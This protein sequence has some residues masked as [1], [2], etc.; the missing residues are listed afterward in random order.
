MFENHVGI[1][2]TS[3]KIQLVEI[4]FDSGRFYLNNIDEEYFSEFIDFSDKETKLLSIIQSSFDD[5]LLRRRL[6]SNFVSFSVPH[7]QF[8]FAQ[9]PYDKTLVVNDLIEHFKWELSLMYPGERPEELALQHIEV[10]KNK[11]SLYDAVI[12]IALKKRIIKLLNQ[13]CLSNKLKLKYIDNVHL[14]AGVSSQLSEKICETSLT[15]SAFISENYLSIEFTLGSD[16]IRFKVY[17]LNHAGEIIPILKDELRDKID[18]N[19]NP[20]MISRA[21]VL[22]DNVTE[23]FIEQA[24]NQLNIQFKKINPFEKIA[25]NEEIAD[26]NFLLNKTFSFSSAAGIAYRLI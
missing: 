6:S 20:R 1:N 18:F 21:V 5:M 23:S 4:I 16:P 10:H 17:P 24:R 14:A 15:L 7:D 12:V 26:N 3:S 11:F 25:V 8:L 22:G 19:I 2:L 9:I 13:F